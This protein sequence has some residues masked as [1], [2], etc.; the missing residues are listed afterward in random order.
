M[1]VLYTVGLWTVAPAVKLA[2]RPKIEGQEHIPTTGGAIFAGNHLS[3]ADEF[4]LGSA[5]SRHISFWAKEDYFIGTGL[6]GM[7]FR[8]LM[9]G[10][11]A[12]PVHRS[13][14]RAALSAFDAAIPVLQEGGLVAVYPEGTRSPDGRL[15]RGRTGAARLA[16]AADVPIIPVG[17]IGTERVQPIGQALPNLRAGDVTIKF[18]KPIEVGAWRDAESASTAAREITD[19]VMMAIQSLTGQEYVARYAPKRQS[20]EE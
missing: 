19:T 7:F 17:T 9:G 15:Y 13:G 6:S 2:W 1:P 4:F 12:I 10:L 5:V 8:N 3:V 18:G 14:G 11:G 20:A 16:L